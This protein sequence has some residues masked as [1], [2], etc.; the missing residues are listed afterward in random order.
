MLFA[1]KP[2]SY[3]SVSN[4]CATRAEEKRMSITCRIVV[5]AIAGVLVA[6]PA[7]AQGLDD[8]VTGSALITFT[9]G[10]EQHWQFSAKE[11]RDGTASGQLQLVTSQANGGKIHGSIFCVASDPSTGIARIAAIVDRS[12]TP[13]A[14]VGAYM[15]WTVRD[16][17]PGEPDQTSDLIPTGTFSATFHC[18]VGFNLAM[19]AAE[20]GEISVHK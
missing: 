20:R 17:G 14:P 3:E 4:A 5:I 18:S 2:P 11:G 10:G 15:I 7:K 13:L 1:L 19:L 8:L 9:L 6:G 16:G 12:T